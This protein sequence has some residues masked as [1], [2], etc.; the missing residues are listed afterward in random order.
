MLFALPCD[1]ERLRLM[2]GP[3]VRLVGLTPRLMDVFF[4][5]CSGRTDQQ[6]AIAL[7]ITGSTVATEIKLISARLGVQGRRG[8]WSV[9]VGMLLDAPPPP[10][11][12]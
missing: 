2:L 8:I 11:P 6:I 10:P 5:V 12:T 7:G 4:L 9:C 3:A 1:P